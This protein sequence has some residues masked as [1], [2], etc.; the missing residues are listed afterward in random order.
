ML[1]DFKAAGFEL[2]SDSNVLANPADD[3]TVKI[4]DPAIRGHTDRMALVFKKP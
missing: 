2:V 3:R 1:A 4:F